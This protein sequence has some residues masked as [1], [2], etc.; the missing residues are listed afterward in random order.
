MGRV[1]IPTQMGIIMKVVG[2]ATKST[3]LEYITIYKL[4]K[5]MKE[6]GKMV[7]NMGMVN[8]YLL[9]VINMMEPGKEI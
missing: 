6:I 9:T 7:K 5:N 8:I 2:W 4:K 3:D 1:H